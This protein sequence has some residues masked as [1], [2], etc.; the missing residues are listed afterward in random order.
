MDLGKFIQ[1]NIFYSPERKKEINESL[2]R[3]N[4]LLQE[5]PASLGQPLTP[6]Q[7][8]F[9]E[10]RSTPEA[11]GAVP[12]S[13]TGPLIPPIATPG[14]GGAGALSPV[15]IEQ[16]TLSNIE[17]TRKG[18]KEVNI[19][20]RGQRATLNG[21][22]VIAD[23]YGNWLDASNSSI[24]MSQRPKVGKYTPGENRTKAQS[25]ASPVPIKIENYEVGGVEYDVETGRAINPETG[26]T[27]DSGYSIDPKTSKRG[28]LGTDT[29]S[30][31]REV[32]SD[33]DEAMRIWARTHGKLADRVIEKQ[34]RRQEINP[35]YQQ[36]GYAAIREVRR[37][38][39]VAYAP[40]Q[41]LSGMNPAYTDPDGA[42]KDLT[43]EGIEGFPVDIKTDALS[44]NTAPAFTEISPDGLVTS[45][46]EIVKIPDQLGI[47]P[48]TLPAGF[49]EAQ[50]EAQEYFSKELK[51][52]MKK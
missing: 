27:S 9:R 19:V 1:D 38:N 16:G 49:T 13:P 4:L 2:Q 21:K 45:G 28:P 24:P 33:A 47:A 7:R 48:Q 25:T 36:A 40:S 31:G 6:A 39:E 12:A 15:T 22:P 46:G 37:P 8:K 18:D 26:E 44:T 35:D 10:A 41:D 50:K 5:G 43:R 51:K 20:Q 17:G 30:G 42:V 29:S 34:E 52:N 3:T 23:G 32:T 14:Y 11:M